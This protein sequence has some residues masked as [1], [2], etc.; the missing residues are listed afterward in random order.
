MRTGGRFQGLTH[1]VSSTGPPRG[2]GNNFV[3]ISTL[4]RSATAK[5][6]SHR[7]PVAYSWGTHLVDDARRYDGFSAGARYLSIVERGGLQR[8]SSQLADPAERPAGFHFSS[9]SL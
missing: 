9:A 7:A 4:V 2:E 8:G 6:M 5:G 3:R 1:S